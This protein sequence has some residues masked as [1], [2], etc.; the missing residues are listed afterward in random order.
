MTVTNIIEPIKTF[1]A[2]YSGLTSGAALMID[3]LGAV[4]T[5]YSI[6]PLPGSKVI[7]TYINGASKREYPFAFQA[8][9]S[10]ADEA[11]R[12]VNNGFFEDFAAWLESQTNAGTLPTMEN[13]KTAESI[14]AVGW[15]FISEQGESETAIYQI[16]CKLTYYQIA[17]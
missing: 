8:T 9:L 16:T 12:I 2:T 5:E 15:G 17:P 4:P 11:A 3:K 10:T 1:I 14:E 7:E 6:M 13:G